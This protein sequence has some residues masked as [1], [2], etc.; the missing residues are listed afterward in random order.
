[1][2]R[3]RCLLCRPSCVS[4]PRARD[5]QLCLSFAKGQVPWGRP[6]RP[7]RVGPCSR[8]SCSQTS[9]AGKPTGAAM[10]LHVAAP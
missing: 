3:G 7:L 6:E 5:A 2:A 4:P 10:H 8:L 9:L 1:M